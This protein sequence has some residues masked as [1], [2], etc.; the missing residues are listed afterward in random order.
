MGNRKHEI[1]MN[2]TIKDSRPSSGLS[3]GKGLSKTRKIPAPP[4]GIMGKYGGELPL[5]NAMAKNLKKV[6]KNIGIF[7]Q[8]S[9]AFNGVFTDLLYSMGV[10]YRALKGVRGA[11]NAGKKLEGSGARLP[12]GGGGS[13]AKGASTAAAAGMSTAAMAAIAIPLAAIVATAVV[14]GVAGAGVAKATGL[15]KNIM[16]ITGILAVLLPGGPFIAAMGTSIALLKKGLETSESIKALQTTIAN[17]SA[18]ILDLAM[19]GIYTLIEKFGRVQKVI[20][21]VDFVKDKVGDVKGAL[22]SVYFR[23]KELYDTADFQLKLA[24]AKISGVSG[25]IGEVQTVL[26]GGPK[27]WFDYFKTTAVYTKITGFFDGDVVG[28]ALSAAKGLN[29]LLTI[30]SWSPSDLFDATATLDLLPFID[31]KLSPADI[32]NWEGKFSIGDF[33]ID[34][35]TPNDIVNFTEGLS[36]KDLFK[37]DTYLD[38]L[39]Y[40]NLDEFA[41]GIKSSL[42]GALPDWVKYALRMM[43]YDI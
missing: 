23:V 17:G 41:E 27:A 21:A 38:L 18:S 9:N 22:Q 30:G 43:G 24:V 7:A 25:A 32:M 1:A 33:D 40:M 15:D 28:T 11:L 42:E 6:D 39:D 16:T 31:A 5:T 10:P 2:V 26:T 3:N 29:D 19:F 20:T 13:G 35:L 37:A 14:G 36:I 8:L 34:L 12:S 4:S